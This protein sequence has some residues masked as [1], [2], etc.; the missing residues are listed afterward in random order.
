[1]P[2]ISHS[3]EAGVWLLTTPRTSYALRI[4]E[5]GAPGHVAWGPG[6]SLAEALELAVP[7]GEAHSSFEG[8][9]AVGEELP[10]D[11][12]LHYGPPSLQVRHADGTRG[13]EWCLEGH[14]VLRPSPGAEE[15]VLRFRDRLYPLQVALHY[16]VREDT[17]VIERRTV[18]RNAGGDHIDLLRADSA[19]WTLPP[20]PGY[21]LSH[22]T[23]QWSAETQLRREPLPYGETVLTGRRGITGHHANPWVMVDAGEADEEHGR[24][25]S[26]AL[27][28][29]G[30]WRVTVQRT[31]DGL[32]GLTTGVG[33]EG[34][35]L[36]LGPGEEFETPV[37]AGLFT[38]GGFGATTRAWHAYIRAHV[39][40]RADELAP[41]LYNSW[42]A[43]G[44]DVA[45][46]GQKMLA[47]RAAAL[48]V[49]LF[50]VDDGWFGARRSDRAG[51]GDWTPARDRFPHGLGPLADHVHGLGMRFG[52]WVE[53]EMVN[54]DSDLYREHPD[55]VLH[56]PGRPRTEM[57]NQ[58]VLDFS[59][60]EIA[61]WAYDWLTRLVADHGVDFLKWDM[62]RAFGEAGRPGE[63][64]GGDA[65][66]TRYVTNLYGVLD[67]LR[68]DHPRLR[69]ETCSGGGGRVDLGIL[70]RTDQAWTSD[71]TDAEDRL[72]IQHG[73]AQIY[74][75]CS[76]SA[77][78]TDVPNQL[79]GRS[80]PLSFR[81]HVAMS[82]LLGIGGDLSRWTEEEVTEA[83]EL[84]ATY[85]RVRH[86]VQRGVLHRLRGPAGEGPTVVQY[87]A[88][89]ADEVLVLAWQRGP[90][91]GAPR[92]PVRL[93]GLPPGARYR[94]TRTGT[95]HHATVLTDYGLHLNLPLGDWASK[96]LHL[97]RLTP[98]GEGR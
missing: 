46:D 40:P 13:F 93:R 51:L 37:C 71:N 78:V 52:L 64:G 15:L 61:D 26:A 74:P 3:P 95:V 67:R 69:I 97:V 89:D 41:V 65:L 11:D 18:L 39:L 45:E 9:R 17:D 29:S 91:H 68:A 76:M 19:A 30:S 84:V 63:P 7:L 80:V 12:G 2:L 92:Q 87:V 35:V 66:W 10:A 33:H 59:R 4:D 44:F 55:W 28:W 43:T 85:K 24:V 36:P 96:A 94:D 88:E 58:L 5:T 73:F 90:R 86:L 49:E 79:T 83:A 98:H 34:T 6:L 14:E 72:A 22:V 16:R 1:M 62:N 31:P 32:A 8:R 60:Q 27:A 38:D 20:L 56:L 23:G 57:R 53:P 48:G 77:W 70:A 82:G 81:F 21:R 47:K 25:W 75:A 54:P 42:E 50:V